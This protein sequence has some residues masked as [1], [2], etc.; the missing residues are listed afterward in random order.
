M[1]QV[2][3]HGCTLDENGLFKN[4]TLDFYGRPKWTK[5]AFSNINKSFIN[6]NKSFINI[7]KSFININKY[8]LKLLNIYQY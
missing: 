2:V 5:R 1:F 6:I 4:V 7:N 8:L 3:R